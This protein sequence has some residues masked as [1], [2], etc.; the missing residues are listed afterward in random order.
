[1]AWGIRVATRPRTVGQ[2]T[3]FRHIGHARP[4]F[5]KSE[6]RTPQSL[7][8]CRRG[9]GPIVGDGRDYRAAQLRDGRYVRRGSSGRARRSGRPPST[10]GA[11]D[12]PPGGRQRLRRRGSAACC[13]VRSTR[14]ARATGTTAEPARPASA[15]ACRSDQLFSPEQLR[16][17]EPPGFG[18]LGRIVGPGSRC[19]F[20][21]GDVGVNGPWLAAGLEAPEA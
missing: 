12:L 19:R 6:E 20:G 8:P 21:D 13:H 11:A 10:R 5:C 9:Q 14:R 17:D 1:M 16:G 2:R 18:Q 4:R 3:G 7:S 15:S